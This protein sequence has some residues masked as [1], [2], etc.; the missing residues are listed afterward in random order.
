MTII[1]RRLELLWNESPP[2]DNQDDVLGLMVYAIISYCNALVRGN[3]DFKMDLGSMCKH[4]HHGLGYLH[5]PTHI[6]V[7]PHC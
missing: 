3:E 6:V 7:L 1:M 2:G 5:L 4:M